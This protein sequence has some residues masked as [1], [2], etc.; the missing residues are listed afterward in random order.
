MAPGEGAVREVA[1]F[2]LDH[3]HFSGVPPTALVSCQEMPKA[4][5]ASVHSTETKIG[6]L[7]VFR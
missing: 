2:L 5:S 7:Q 1:A 6:S 3:D 4:Q